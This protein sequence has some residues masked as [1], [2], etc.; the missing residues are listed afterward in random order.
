MFPLQAL[1]QDAN[2]FRPVTAIKQVFS[3]SSEAGEAGKS[4]GKTNHGLKNKTNKSFPFSDVSSL[5]M[6][7]RMFCYY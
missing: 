4:Q 6:H 2:K 3:I 1:E 7:T 5:Y